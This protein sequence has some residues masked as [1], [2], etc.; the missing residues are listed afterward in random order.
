MWLAAP[1]AMW[2]RDRGELLIFSDRVN[3]PS[4]TSAEVLVVIF[5]WAVAK[6]SPRN[7]GR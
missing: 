1:C 4:D 6:D 3:G 5:V 2:G 7:A